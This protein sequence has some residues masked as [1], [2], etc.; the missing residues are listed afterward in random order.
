MLLNLLINYKMQKITKRLNKLGLIVGR[1]P[2][3]TDEQLDIT[4]LEKVWLE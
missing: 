4:T 3:G 1:Y 2:G